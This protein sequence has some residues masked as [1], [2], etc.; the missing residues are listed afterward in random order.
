MHQRGRSRVESSV[1]LRLRRRRG[2]EGSVTLAATSKHRCC[3][4]NCQIQ[5]V[6][7][8]KN[9]R[10]VSGSLAGKTPLL[11]AEEGTAAVGA[12]RR[13][14]IAGSPFHRPR[15]RVAVAAC[16]S[17]N[18][19]EPFGSAEYGTVQASKAGRRRCRPSSTRARR[20]SRTR[21]IRCC[22]V[23]LKDRHEYKECTVRYR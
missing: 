12:A 23:C 18:D 10:E 1:L 22:G 20:R 19:S 6:R 5:S 13:D 14:R 17:T 11:R 9:W 21:R 7:V 2:T 15:H 8:A 4:R 16:Q 3:S